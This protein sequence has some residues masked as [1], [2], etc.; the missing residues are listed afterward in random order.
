M[1]AKEERRG[2][3]TAAAARRRSVQ[4]ST[5]HGIPWKARLQL[6]SLVRR[7]RFPRHGCSWG[8][9]SNPHTPLPSRSQQSSVVKSERPRPRACVKCE[10]RGLRLR[11][12]QERET[13]RRRIYGEEWNK[14]SNAVVWIHHCTLLLTNHSPL[15]CSS[16]SS[17]TT[18]KCKCKC[19]FVLFSPSFS[20]LLYGCV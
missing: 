19:C 15:F 18:D 17:S 20:I 3:S 7:S 4:R 12:A 13:E 6:R 10:E 8:S 5:A 2:T 9:W 14:A 1:N 16:S 11:P